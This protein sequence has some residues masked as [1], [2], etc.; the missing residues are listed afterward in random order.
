LRQSEV[1]DEIPDAMLA[2]RQMLENRQSRGV[3]KRVE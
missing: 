3:P 1:L 2:G